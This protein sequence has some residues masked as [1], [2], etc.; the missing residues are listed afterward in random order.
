MS[1][2]VLVIGGG[3]AGIQAALDLADAGARVLLVEREPTI[4]GIMAV[5][6]KNFPT[7][8][9]SICIEAPK[10]S[11]VDLHP[12]IEVLSMAEVDS[13]SGGP[14]AFDVRLRL[15]SRFVTDECTRCGDCV[16]ACPVPLP[17]EYDSGMATRKAIYTP[18][19]Q[20]VPGAYVIDL[21]TCLNDP[22]N[23]LPCNHCSDVCPPKAID[24]LMPK[25][26]FLTR[27]V[28]S[29][30]VAVGYDSFD[31]RLMDEYGYGKHP[32]ILTAL[33]FE[34]LINSAG[35]TGGEIIK[36]SNGEHPQNILFVLCVGSRDQRHFRYCSRFCCMYSIKHA[37][38]AVDHKIPEVAVMYM[39]VRAYGKGFDGFWMRTQEA[40]ASFIRGRPSRICPNGNGAI[41]VDY[42]DALEMRR[43]AVDY[44]MVVL[45]TAVTPPEGLV[46]LS[47]RLGIELDADGFIRSMEAESG[48]IAT[49]RPG[50]YAAGCVSGPKDIPDSVAEGSGA[51][52]LAL[53]HL[54]TKYWPEPPVIEPIEDI[55]HPKVGVF[56][57]HCG[58]NI[59]G[60][61]DVE[62]VVK[63][64][65][66]LPDVV[67]VSSQMF[68]C[69]GNTQAE[70]EEAIKSEGINRV[71][72]AA[73]SP[74]THE[75]IFRGVMLRSG[76]NPFL[77]EMSNIRN[78]DSW[79][80]K[81]EKEAATTKAVDMVSMAVEKA[82]RLEPLE[83]SELPLTQSALVIGGGIAGVTAA[84]AL[85]DQGFE[86]HLVEQNDRL[87]G[88]L[89]ELD[90][91]S[92]AGLSADE[93][94][95]V[96]VRELKKSGVHL[97][98][99][100]RVD[101][102]GGFVGNFHAKLTDGK[103]L[104]IGAIVVATGAGA[105]Q[106]AH[107]GWGSDPSVITN[108]ELE[109]LLK[110]GKIEAERVT[111]VACVG[112]RQ[113]DV[114]CSRYCCTSMIAQA[115]RLRKMGKK[116]RVLYKDVRTYSRQAEE[117]YETAMRDGVQF[118]R[119]D[120][121]S[122]PQEAISY[123]DGTVSLYDHL[124]GAEVDIPTDLLV[125]V[126]GMEPRQDDLA[127]QLKLARSE[128]GFYMELHP[129]LGPAET[130]SQGIYLA[131]TAQSAKDVRESMAQALAAS[132]KVGA[133]LSRGII[134]KEPLTAQLH[135]ELCNG[136]MRCVKVCPYSAIEQI[137]KPGEGTIR[138]LDA[139]C[140]GCGNCA[141]ECNFN[142]IE[143]PYFTTDQI[144]A[145]V[146]AALAEN[147]EEKCL[148]FTCNWCSYAGADLAGIEK[149]QYPPSALIIRTM[150]S[151]RF[152]E[153]FVAHAFEQG[154]G[155][156]LIT[157]CRLTD[158]GS[159]CHYN[160]AN[161]QTWKRFKHWQ[162]KY[163]RKGIEAERLQ[164][165]WISAAEGKEFA[166]KITEMHEVV[167]EHARKLKEEDL[168][169]QE[170]SD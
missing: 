9:C 157:G 96:K 55:E 88:L 50:I 21:D 103:D 116:V 128:D 93:L 147:P 3:I 6:D 53:G 92:P 165:Q 16:Q 84:L 70:I 43:R 13:V 39:D 73:C 97:H 35:P 129:K 114:G 58:N 69:A 28:G 37:Y 72:I 112:S 107:F 27:E 170:A 110:D 168:H 144:L 7:L 87:G 122:P 89:T 105:H 8:D 59:A 41:R 98:L 95:K 31:P 60:V 17:N 115:H 78:M 125:L 134:E 65:R 47:N 154:A 132:G 164:L 63:R 133:L 94:I 113:G 42:E 24:F 76:L 106:P 2:S 19:P 155:A 126:V 83:I 33:E 46:D 77:L 121:D 20:A 12:N 1:D 158:T 139:V 22:P 153:S 61:I 127:D 66:S 52:S 4:G 30:I 143:M 149:R 162:R 11:E 156:V 71:V 10:M 80:H 130:A 75:S 111:F 86:T 38:Q 140:M 25:E 123:R 64:T 51:A 40:G 74:K 54:T 81:N 136:C 85:D 104:D 151:A 5:L 26:T 18:I 29:I 167:Q 99:G 62:E 23:Y 57:C 90:E 101:T 102:I 44:D 166:E 161:R 91:I 108:L 109:H 118:F 146:D 142:A 100:N 48:L 145:Q 82:R 138:I 159:D 131:G 34:R 124:L 148:V 56:V 119:F 135:S 79:V 141:A 152:D 36:P 137:G 15:R 160:Y 49:T 32:D 67:H 120:M 45:A 169:P 14:G 117:L 150:C 68:S 163:S